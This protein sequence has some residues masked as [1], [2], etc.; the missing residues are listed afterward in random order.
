MAN[1]QFTCRYAWNPKLEQSSE[2]VLDAIAQIMA[3]LAVLEESARDRDEAV[4]A[5]L[6]SNPQARPG[7]REP[8]RM[9]AGGGNP[10]S[11]PRLFL[12][13]GVILIIVLAIYYVF[14]R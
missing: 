1:R 8:L 10:I 7:M 11:W 5:A 13:I 14:R 2:K 6:R 3:R 4:L 9:N 12:L